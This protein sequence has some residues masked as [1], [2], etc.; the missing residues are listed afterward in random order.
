MYNRTNYVYH[1]YAQKLQGGTS[2]KHFLHHSL[3][4][5]DND[6][7]MA[8]IAALK[9]GCTAKLALKRANRHSQ[10]TLNYNQIAS[11]RER[12]N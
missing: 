2:L 3:Q 4:Y 11:E 8:G 10:H 5:G 1:N 7:Q 12:S 9:P 6:A